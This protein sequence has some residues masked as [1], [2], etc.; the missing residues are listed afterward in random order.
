[1]SNVTVEF[2]FHISARGYRSVTWKQVFCPGRRCIFTRRDWPKMVEPS[3]KSRRRVHL[4]ASASLPAG[5][6]TRSRNT[7]AVMLALPVSTTSA[8]AI[9][10]EIYSPSRAAGFSLRP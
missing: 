9:C 8:P 10:E 5:F 1:L 2:N 4:G 6:R 7:P 3:A